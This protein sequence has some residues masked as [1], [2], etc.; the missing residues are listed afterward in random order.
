MRGI[1]SRLETADGD[2]DGNELA[3]RL[4]VDNCKSLQ[5]GNKPGDSS[6]LGTGAA[7]PR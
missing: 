3:G 5:S 6:P 4:A 2:V 1:L 7:S